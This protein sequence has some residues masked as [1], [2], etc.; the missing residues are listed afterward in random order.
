MINPAARQFEILQ[1]NYKQASRIAKL[2][3]QA[4]LYIYPR[5]T[6]IMYDRRNELLFSAFKNDIIENEFRIKSKCATTENLQAK[7]VL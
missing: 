7:S 4:Q 3:E 5:P 1:Y 2:L 6:I